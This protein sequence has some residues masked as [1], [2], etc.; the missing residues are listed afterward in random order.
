MCLR[1]D[2]LLLE[3]MRMLGLYYI[4]K[5]LKDANAVENLEDWYLALRQE[6]PYELFPYLVEDSGKIEKVYI[7]EMV[8]EDLVRLSV[9]DVT[10]HGRSGGCAAE[11]LPFIKPSGSQSPQVGPVIK[12]TY[13]RDKGAGPSEK[14]LHTTMTYFKE[15]AASSKPWSRYFNEVVTILQCKEIQLLDGSK[16]NWADNKYINILACAVDK[17]GPQTNTVFLTIRT[18]DGK[19]PG[20]QPVYIRYL[21]EEK[22]AGE[23]YV[24]KNA[25]AMEKQ[26]CHLCSQENIKVYPNGLKGA[27]INIKNPDRI[28]AFPGIDAAQAWKGFGICGACADLLGIYKNHVL[29]KGG[30]KKDKIPFTAEVAGEKALIVPSFL[31]NVSQESGLQLLEQVTSYIQSMNDNVVFDEDWLLDLLKDEKAILNLQILWLDIGQNLENIRGMISHVLP[32]RLRQLSELNNESQDWKHSLFPVIQI[33]DAQVNLAPNLSLRA[34]KPLFQ[35]PGGRKAKAVNASI[36]LFQLRRLLAECIYHGVLMEEERFWEEFLLTARWYWVEAI[37]KSSG[38]Y[39][40]LY[41]G[42]G[43]NG[44]YLT[45]AGWIKYM[46][47]WLYYLRKVG[48]FKMSTSYFEPSMAELKPFFGPESGIDSPDKAYAFLLGILYGKVLQVQGAKGVNVGANA[49]TWL[50]RLTLRGRDLPELYNKIREKN[51]AY[52]IEKNE[53]VRQLITEIGLLGVRLGEHISLNDVQ[54]SYY[55]LLGQSMTNTIIPKKEKE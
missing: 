14:I 23:R 38:E 26:T 49:L 43:Q 17:I 8:T 50:K 45:A 18:S 27:G 54:T 20:E 28:G 22:L 6:K 35:R 16:L 32:S 37:Q 24:T 31:P 2:V 36:R 34:L 7:L 12:R 55:L 52:E 3:G 15:V 47:W 33:A 40:L 13:S 51:F 53:K 10:V 41:E 42:L 25:P 48:V 29:K 11:K 46:N 44:P 19:L 9:Q 4:S 30:V 5:E 39:G 1:G 21:L